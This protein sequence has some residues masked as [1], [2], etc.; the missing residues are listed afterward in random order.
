MASSTGFYTTP[1]SD[2]QSQQGLDTVIRV[3][4][5]VLLVPNNWAITLNAFSLSARLCYPCVAPENYIG[6]R[7]LVAIIEI[8]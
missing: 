1:D 8:Y 5:G 2:S 7:I 4:R 6:R 3:I